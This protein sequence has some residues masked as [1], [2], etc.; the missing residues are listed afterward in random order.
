VV[1]RMV[2]VRV[3]WEGEN[4]LC[5]LAFLVQTIYDAYYYADE[6]GCDEDCNDDQPL[7]PSSS[8]LREKASVLSYIREFLALRPDDT[9]VLAVRRRRATMRSPTERKSEHS[10][11]WPIDSAWWYSRWR[12]I[13][14]VTVFV[15]DGEAVLVGQATAAPG[16]AAQGGPLR[17]KGRH[18]RSVSPCEIDEVLAEMALAGR[19]QK[20]WRWA[21]RIERSH[22]NLQFIARYCRRRSPQN[23]LIVMKS[24]VVVG[25]R[26]DSAQRLLKRETCLAAVPFHDGWARHQWHS[27]ASWSRG[28]GVDGQEVPRL[29]GAAVAWVADEGSRWEA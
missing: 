14:P 21:V 16:A 18:W 7:P 20:R 9:V 10:S 23:S 26:Q 11:K 2:L 13:R 17:C 8:L 19:A 5:L 22:C 4:V 1:V 12:S 6:D 3:G 27:I 24:A 28:S 15:D 29:R 25:A